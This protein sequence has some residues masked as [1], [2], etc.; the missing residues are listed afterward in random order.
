MIRNTVGRC[1]LL[2]LGDVAL[3]DKQGEIIDE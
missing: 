2:G 3:L 1:K